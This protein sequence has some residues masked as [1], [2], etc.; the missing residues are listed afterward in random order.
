MANEIATE[1][2]CVNISNSNVNDEGG[3][4]EEDIVNPWNVVS[5]SVT[6]IDYDKLISKYLSRIC[7]D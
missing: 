5:K 6:G 7:T 3:T 4:E 1:I 2:K